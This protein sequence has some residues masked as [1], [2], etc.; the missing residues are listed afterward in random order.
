MDIDGAGIVGRLAIVEPKG[1]SEPCIG[2]GK[3]NEV[4]G[5]GMVQAQVA[6][7]GAAYNPGDARQRSEKVARGRQ[8]GGIVDV[9]MRQL[10]IADCEGAAVERIQLLSE[11]SG[12]RRQQ[13]RLPQSPVE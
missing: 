1:I 3:N 9:D 6:A 7:L 12:P 4:A 11:R 13:A 2:F 10:V 8:V 5:A